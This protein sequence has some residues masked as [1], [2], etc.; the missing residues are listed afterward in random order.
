MT[1]HLLHFVFHKLIALIT[2]LSHFSTCHLHSHL[3]VRKTLVHTCANKISFSVRKLLNA[4]SV[5][6]LDEAASEHDKLVSPLPF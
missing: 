2:H 1:L 4:N 5:G 3:K 6:G